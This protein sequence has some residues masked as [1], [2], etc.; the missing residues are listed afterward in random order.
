[1]ELMDAGSLADI[2][3]LFDQGVRMT[4]PEISHICSEVRS[5]RSQNP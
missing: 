1:M 5:L 4:E 3:E 2:L